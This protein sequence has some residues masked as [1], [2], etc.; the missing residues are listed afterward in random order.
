MLVQLKVNIGRNDAARL[1]LEDTH[2]GATVEVSEKAGAEMIGKGWAVD[3]SSPAPQ[4]VHAVPT[5]GLK[6]DP[7][8]A[9]KPLPGK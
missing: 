1:G 6:A 4:K 7:A 5:V 2:D 8:P 9:T 3:A